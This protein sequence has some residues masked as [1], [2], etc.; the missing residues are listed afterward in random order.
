MS[1]ELIGGFIIGLIIGRIV[2]LIIK[3]ITEYKK[4]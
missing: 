3:I 1:I 4:E 2:W